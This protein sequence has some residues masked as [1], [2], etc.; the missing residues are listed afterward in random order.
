MRIG[1]ITDSHDR[2]PALQAALDRFQSLGIDTILHAGD[3]VAP[4]A[5]KLLAGYPGTVHVVYGNNDGERRGLKS[6]LPQIQDGP[7]LLDLG[8]RRVL[9]HHFIDWCHDAQLD[10]ADV[11]FTGHTHEVAIEQHDDK[12]LINPGECCGWLTGK[13]TV[14]AVE[15]DTL[16]HE[17]IEIPT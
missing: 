2:L 7:L 14:A 4:F 1:L 10:E 15:L 6:V 16:A 3:L 17:L 9:M 12:L 8:G 11:V 13:C 5:A